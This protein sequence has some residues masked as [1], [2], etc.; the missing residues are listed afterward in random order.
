MLVKP[1][2]LACGLVL[3]GPVSALAAPKPIDGVL[4]H[5]VGQWSITGTTL[6]KPAV[7]GAEVEPEFDG[8]FLELHIKDPSGRDS[9][10]AR[11][12][13]G[14]DASGQLVVHWL[15]ATGGETSRTLGGGQ[16]QGDLVTL[17]FPYPDGAFRDRLTYDRAQDRWRLFIEMGPADH[18]R[19]FSDWFF[20]RR[21]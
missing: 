5:F 3:G 19:V 16:V 15:D 4:A 21:N 20:K 8:N 13:F 6:G 9:Y 7:T 2:A 17:N 14:T 11:V 18:P 1:L 12:Y 10:E